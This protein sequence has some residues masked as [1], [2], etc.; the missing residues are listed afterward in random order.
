MSGQS[1]NTEGLR[2]L[3]ALGQAVRQLREERQ[4]SPSEFAEAA[5]I[6][7]ASLEALEAGRFDPPFDVLLALAGA[8]GVEL[9]DLVFYVEGLDAHA[10]NVAFG[11]RL[12]T[13]RTQRGISHARLARRTG[14]H[15]TA[16]ARLE[17]GDRE[18]RLATILRI[19]RALGVQPGAL[20]DEPEHGKQWPTIPPAETG[21]A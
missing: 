8:L 19:A 9:A 17:S 3:I 16:F 1:T 21:S 6:A 5:S 14:V 18:P 11:Q 10:A 2:K 4:L 12:R 15:V 20:L 13:L 7:Q